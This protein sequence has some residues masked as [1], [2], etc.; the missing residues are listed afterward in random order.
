MKRIFETVRN[1]WLAKS[2]IDR[3]NADDLRRKNILLKNEERRLYTE[4]EGTEKAKDQLF[5]QARTKDVSD[6]QRMQAAR[7][8][9][10]LDNRLKDLDRRLTRN[11]KEQRMVEGILR[12]K[13]QTSAESAGSVLQDVD[14]NE[15]RE[16]IESELVAQQIADEKSAQILG[17]LDQ[18]SSYEV[19]PAVSEAQQAIYE[20][21]CRASEAQSETVKADV[22]I[23]RDTSNESTTS[24]SVSVDGRMEDDW[25]IPQSEPATRI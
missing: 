1:K 22:A 14:P 23:A 3:L 25:Q 20:Q 6:R 18:D 13:E 10:G 17:L 2:S 7:K 12:M 8:I 4:I 16:W 24:R 15:L 11:S 9:E 5:D 21:I 19:N